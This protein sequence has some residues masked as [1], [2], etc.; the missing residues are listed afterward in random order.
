M[1]FFYAFHIR[2]NMIRSA[3]YRDRIPVTR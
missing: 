2:D 3:E 1:V